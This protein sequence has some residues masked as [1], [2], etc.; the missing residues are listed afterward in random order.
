[1]AD[2]ILIELDLEKGDVKSAIKGIS[3]AGDKAGQSAAAN[4]KKKFSSGV[5][6][7][8]KSLGKQAFKVGSILTGVA[9]ALI[10]IQSIRAAQVQEDAVNALNSALSITKNAGLEASQGIQNYASEL[11]KS[12]RFG[13]EVLIQNAA[14]IQSLGDLDEKGLK[15]ALAA[16]TDLA[17]ALRIDLTAAATLVGKAA[18]GEVGSFSRY[19]LSIKKASNNTETFANAL[20]QIENKFGGA[21][22]RDVLTFSGSVDQLQNAFGDVLEEIG[23][24]ITQNPK[25]IKV[26][27]FAKEALE[28]IGSE[29]SGFRE[30]N[31]AFSVLTKGALALG[32]TLVSFVIKP[33]E[34]VTA[35]FSTLKSAIVTGFTAMGAAGAG[36]NLVIAKAFDLV[37]ASVNLQSFQQQFDTFSE[38]T[39]IGANNTKDAFSSIFELPI[40]SQLEAKR[41]ELQTFF[42]QINE[43]A[44]VQKEITKENTDALIGET[45]NQALGLQDIFAGVSTGISSGLDGVGADF[46][47]VQKRIGKFSQESGK[48]LQQGFAKGAGDAFAEFGKAAANGENALEAFGKALIKS[49]GQQA[50]TLGTKFILE[51]TAYLFSP[52]FQGLGAPLIAAGAGLAAFGGALGAI[53][54]GGG[55]SSGGSSAA[56][57]VDTNTG[58][59]G[60]SPETLADPALTTQ[61]EERTNVTLN[62]EGS[63]IRESEASD[64]LTDL[65]ETSGSRNSSIIPS[66]RTGTA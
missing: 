17:S 59:G 38:A 55:A 18:A 48:A 22:Q 16:T 49:I 25:F 63:V 28:G 51:G 6:G 31:D 62:I 54:G 43:D 65:L 11:Q 32:D 45:A 20:T 2:K 53:S 19:G 66:L 41:N 64:W 12:T 33:V 35:V 42:T 1:M 10:G 7:S 26:I 29:I 24:V 23:K 47:S 61:A 34:A 57:S 39:K 52:G 44:L 56:N 37:G 30:G 14:L 58:N 46:E 15:R 36:F 40:S 13:D 3:D 9:T 27:N 21:S 60:I 4:F 8:F 5:A 50:I